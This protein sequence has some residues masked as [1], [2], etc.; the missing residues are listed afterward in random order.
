MFII[1]NWLMPSYGGQV[2]WFAISRLEN[3]EAGDMDSVPVKRP[4]NREWGE[5]CGVSQIGVWPGPGSPCLRAGEDGYLSSN[6]K[7]IDPSS[8]FCSVGPCLIGRKPSLLTLLTQIL[9]SSGDTSSQKYPEIEV[10]QLSGHPFSKSGWPMKL[11]IIL[12][13]LSIY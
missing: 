3:Q 7:Q 4:K 10:L 1:R 9:V 6:R 8:T 13:Q 2:P 12:S 11:I 5:P